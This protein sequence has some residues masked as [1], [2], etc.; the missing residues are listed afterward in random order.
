MDGS[1]DSKT[2]IL[3]GS[4]VFLL[5]MFI[6]SLSIGNALFYLLEYD[7]YTALIGYL[8]RVILQLFFLENST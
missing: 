4:G 3:K 1:V 6:P 8:I 5:K 2:L 7:Y